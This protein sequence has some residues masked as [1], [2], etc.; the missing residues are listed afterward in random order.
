MKG[1][2]PFDLTASSRY[3]SMASLEISLVASR[4][5]AAQATIFPINIRAGAARCD[6][7]ST[8][9]NPIREDITL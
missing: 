5:F 7:R 6:E 4:V 9:R 2:C 8:L 3:R 1:T